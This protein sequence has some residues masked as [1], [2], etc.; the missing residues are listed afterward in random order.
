LQRRATIGIIPFKSAPERDACIVDANDTAE[1]SFGRR[2]RAERER[3]KI[4]LE[5]IAANTKI[6]IGLLRSLERDDFS[7]WPSGLFRRSFVRGYAEAIGIDPEETVREFLERFPDSLGGLDPT[8]ARQDGKRS[9]AP[10]ATLRLTLADPPS[11]FAAGPLLARLRP[12]FA[13]V[14]FDV[15]ATLSVAVSAFILTTEFW[16]PFAV[17]VLSYYAVSILV[18]GNTPGVYLFGPRQPGARVSAEILPLRTPD[19][20][21]QEGIA[22]LGAQEA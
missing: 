20:T 17:T 19:S 15:L 18:L 22:D 8:L 7:R 12:R 6:G 4:A 3:R 14:A 2:L 11:R 13:A 16:P 10:A 1:G 9:Q 21:D 5:T